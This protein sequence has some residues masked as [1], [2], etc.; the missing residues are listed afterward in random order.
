MLPRAK[1]V[2]VDDDEHE[3]KQLSE[4]FYNSGIP[5]LPLQYNSR[6]GVKRYGIEKSTDIRWLFIDIHLESGTN[7]EAASLVGPIKEIISHLIGRGIYSLVFW[8]KHADKVEEIIA[9]IK[10][11][12][13]LSRNIPPPVS[14]ACVDKNIFIEDATKLKE[15]IKSTLSEN[16]LVSSMLRWENAV[17]NASS[18]ILTKVHQLAKSNDS[19]EINETRENIKNIISLL[20][21][22]ASGFERARDD[23]NVSLNRGLFSLVEDDYSNITKKDIWTGF[24][25]TSEQQLK[26]V[27]IDIKVKLNTYILTEE[28]TSDRNGGALY[29]KG[30]ISFIDRKKTDINSLFGNADLDT[31]IKEEF[32]GFEKTVD[33]NSVILGIIEVS[34]DCD[35]ANKKIKIHRFVLTSLIP[36]EYWSK[37]NKAQHDGIF[38]EIPNVLYKGKQYKL[39]L[40]FKYIISIPFSDGNMS[41]FECEALRLKDDMLVKIRTE[42]ARYI[43]RPG[44]TAIH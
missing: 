16:R 14:Y 7:V 8:S 20:A 36:S 12:E 1:V 21:H 17:A 30:V 15:K 43:S 4:A 10:N 33:L 41:M 38:N 31:I 22:E 39:L 11:D 34:P 9:R 24:E 18:N 19:W 40:S 35:H 26:Q 6:D 27:P 29:E 23:A 37:K 42:M 3:L 28:I 13:D 5:C 25:F 32:I 2:I 44:Y